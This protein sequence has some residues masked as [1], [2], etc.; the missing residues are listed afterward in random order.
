[1]TTRTAEALRLRCLAELEAILAT[2]PVRLPG[3]SPGL[4]VVIDYGP[5]LAALAALLEHLS[6]A[7][8]PA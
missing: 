3:P 4:L 8:R 7:R 2:E 5:N 1:M 6:P